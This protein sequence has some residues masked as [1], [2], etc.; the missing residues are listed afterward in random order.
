[1]VFTD[2]RKEAHRLALLMRNLGFPAIPIHGQMT[3]V[4]KHEYKTNMNI[5]KHE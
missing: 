3:Q 5:K 4:N 2:T 1:M